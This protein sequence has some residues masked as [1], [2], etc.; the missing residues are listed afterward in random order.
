MR[1]NDRQTCSDTTVHAARAGEGLLSDEPELSSARHLAPRILF[2]DDEQHVVDGLRRT[3]REDPYQ[4]ETATSADSALRKFRDEAFDVVVADE[5]MPGMCGSDLLTIIANEF[6][7]TGRILLTGHGTVEAAARAINEAGIVRFLLKPCQPRELRDAIETALKTTPFE[8]RIRVGGRRTYLVSHKDGPA[9][10]ARTGALSDDAAL[11]RP[12]GRQTHAHPRAGHK[13]WQANELVLQAQ[14]MLELG[15]EMLR[16]FE[17]SARLQSHNGNV[18]TIGNFIASSG[19][20]VLLSAVDRWVVRHVLELIREHMQ[21]LERR[22]LMVSLNLAAQS[23]ADADFVQFLDDE[24]SEPRIASRFLIEI[25]ESALAKCL[26]RDE[27]AL[28]GLLA[29]RCYDRGARLSI[30]GVGGALWKLNV[31]RDLPVS[32][33]KLDSH[34]VCDILTSPQSESLVR[35]AVAWG[36]RTGT[37]VAA[38]GIDTPAIAARLHALGVQYGQGSVYGTAEPVGLTLSGLYC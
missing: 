23:L 10:D 4:I 6:P 1:M 38:T 3:L 19:Q 22:G 17:L 8:K 21:I 12:H 35:A 7:T 13:E 5:R 14:R 15:S 11:A 30:D 28:A 26:T 37:A 16:G 31:L 25:R 32:L 36:Q 29:M 27:G 2:V 9:R 24:L 18:H 20:R 34:Y 33:A